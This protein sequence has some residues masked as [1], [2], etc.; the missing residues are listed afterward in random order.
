MDMLTP[1]LRLGSVTGRAEEGLFSASGEFHGVMVRDVQ[2]FGEAEMSPVPV[3]VQF[4]GV[5]A[6][7]IGMTGPCM[8][9][10]APQELQVGTG[11]M[12]PNH[13]SGT[14]TAPPQMEHVPQTMWPGG[15]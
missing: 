15:M 9:A 1:L 11:G 5:G 3:V 4:G 7:F 6:G 8:A 12:T 13:I 14:V 2:E 10:V